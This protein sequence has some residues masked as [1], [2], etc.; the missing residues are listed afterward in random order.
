M[1]KE[2]VSFAAFLVS[3]I[4]AGLVSSVT[5]VP[6]H[7]LF[8]ALVVLAAVGIAIKAAMKIQDLKWLLNNGVFIYLLS[9]YITFT[10]LFNLGA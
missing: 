3:G 7:G 5:R 4:V 8:V 2:M 1:E 10:I 6:L 9:W